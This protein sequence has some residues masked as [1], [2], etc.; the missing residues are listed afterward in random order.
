[1]LASIFQ[2]DAEA[3]PSSSAI[4]VTLRNTRNSNWRNESAIAVTRDGNFHPVWID[5]GRGEGEIRTTAIHV[6]SADTLIAAETEGL[7]DVTTKVTMLYGGD[8]AYDAKSKTLTLDVAIKNKSTNAIGTPFKIA[9]PRLSRD[10]HFAAIANATNSVADAGAVW[11]ITRSVPGGTLN[12]G[13]TTKPFSLK[14][15][16]LLDDDKERRSDGILGFD[17]R[18]FAGDQRVLESH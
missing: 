4:T 5:A 10:F 6:T 14:F 7:S 8:Q 18:V 2:A 17:L 12:P 1:M 15:R 16:Y 11:D 9:I 3:K 13:A